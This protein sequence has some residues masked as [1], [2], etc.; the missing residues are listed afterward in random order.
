MAYHLDPRSLSKYQFH[1][2]GLQGKY[3]DRSGLAEPAGNC[4]VGYY[5]PS[6]EIYP[7]PIDKLCQPGHYCPLGSFK[8]NVCPPGTY[9]PN[10]GRGFCLDCSNGYYC[11]PAEAQGISLY[12]TLF[13]YH[14]NKYLI[15]YHSL[16]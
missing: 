6:G 7:S 1:F 14:S 15:D 10:A 9:Q 5:C 12:F 3:C 13:L 8:H 4:S 11:D 16:L 2:L